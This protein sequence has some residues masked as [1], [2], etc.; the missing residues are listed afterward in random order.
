MKYKILSPLEQEVMNIVW[1]LKSCHIRNVLEKIGKTKPL[2]YTTVATLLQR[3]YE[4]GM[5][6]RKSEGLAFAY[7]PRFTRKEYCKNIAKSFLHNFF[8]S[9]GESA[10]V[11]FAESVENLPKKKRKD[12]LKLLGTHYENK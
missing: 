2:A 3:L 11:S 1:E 7:S 5:V 12:F 8:K 6:N 9:F 10:I 4:K